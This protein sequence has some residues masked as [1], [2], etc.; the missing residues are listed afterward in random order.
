MKPTKKHRV[1]EVEYWD[2]GIAKHSHKT[3]AVAQSCIDKQKQ[4]KTTKKNNS[5]TKEKRLELVKLRDSGLT[6]DEI[7]Y[8]YGIGRQQ[9]RSVYEQT[10]IRIQYKTKEGWYSPAFWGLSQNARNRL[11]EAGFEPKKDLLISA[12]KDGSIDAR[13]IP[14]IGKKTF[15]ELKEWA[16]KDGNKR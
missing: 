15:L 10:L 5:W 13:K 11:I 2:C 9:A 6:F 16:L 8:R 3:E 12:I 1:I 4:K 14:N 7:G